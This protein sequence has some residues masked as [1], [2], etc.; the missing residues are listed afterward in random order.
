MKV[1]S[2]VLIVLTLFV[3]VFG[4]LAQFTCMCSSATRTRRANVDAAV[5]A[6]ASTG[7]FKVDITAGKKHLTKGQI[8]M[9]NDSTTA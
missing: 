4:F 6:Q 5:L 7:S 8:W 3:S 1:P 2:Y 9:P